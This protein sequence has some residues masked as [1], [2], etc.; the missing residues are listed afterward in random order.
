MRGG[1]EGGAWRF[2]LSMG[3]EMTW[4]SRRRSRRTV[5]LRLAQ[6]YLLW[7]SGPPGIAMST[8]SMPRRGRSALCI[9]RIAQTGTFL[10]PPPHPSPGFTER[11]IHTL[12]MR[13]HASCGLEGVRDVCTH[14][15]SQAAL[16]FR[17]SGS[18]PNADSVTDRPGRNVILLPLLPLPRRSAD[19]CPAHL[20][21]FVPPAPPRAAPGPCAC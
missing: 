19:Y 13:T 4:R 6:N 11:P 12:K 15:C 17:T 5:R 14:L 1:K 10:S 21:P 8:S 20:E 2:R 18:D 3:M 7:A 16:L 9:L